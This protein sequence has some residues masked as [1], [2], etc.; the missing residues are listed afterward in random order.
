MTATDGDKDRPQNIVYFLTGQGIDPD[1]PANSKF[2][3]NR[4]T[5]EIFVLKVSQA[6][7]I[8][9]SF[10]IYKIIMLIC[11]ISI[12][13]T[14]SIT[15]TLLLIYSLK[16]SLLI[17][18]FQSFTLPSYLHYFFKVLFYQNFSDFYAIFSTLFNTVFLD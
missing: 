17:I 5:G 13:F 11:S 7:L 16:A 4:T 9:I 8:C 10:E 6:K 3:I 15:I 14:H 2:D 18:P 1:N 12:I